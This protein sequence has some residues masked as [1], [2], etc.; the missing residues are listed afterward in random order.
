MTGEPI[1]FLRESDDARRSRHWVHVRCG[2]SVVLERRVDTPN[3]VVDLL[4]CRYCGQWLA[5]S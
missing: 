5:W 3:G 4:K 1:P 2:G